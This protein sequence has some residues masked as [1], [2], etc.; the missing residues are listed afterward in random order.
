MQNRL[1]E[2]DVVLNSITIDYLPSIDDIVYS[3]LGRFISLA[4][5]VCLYVGLA[6]D[7]YGGMGASYVLKG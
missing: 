1:E 7:F 4:A 6:R 3:P 5:N 2:E